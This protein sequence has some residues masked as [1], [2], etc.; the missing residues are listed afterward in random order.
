MSARRISS[1]PAGR[2]ALVVVRALLSVVGILLAWQLLLDVLGVQGFVAKGPLAV[3]DWLTVGSAAAAHRSALLSATLT[4]LSHAAP[5][6]VI[7]A[8]VAFGAA[9][10]AVSSRV[11]NQIV[12]PVAVMFS[13]V[14]ILVVTPLIIVV[15]GRGF[16]ATTTIC[17]V[18]TFF[19]TFIYSTYGLRATPPATIDVMRAF[20]ASR[21]QILRYGQIPAA[22][23]Y[24]VAGAR[25]AAPGAIVGALIAEWLAT[26]NGLGNIMV[27]AQT[28]FDYSEL[29]ASVAVATLLGLSA[30]GAARLA[31]NALRRRYPLD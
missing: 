13:A 21:A 26:G 22:V 18:I 28:V 30:Y 29:W 10:L 6:Y 8:L 27:S 31:E 4:T 23:P 14:P 17:V 1:S 20:D 2:V 5:G 16:S 11:T 3:W 15:C 25:I 7:G 9:V 24:A 19:P 12:T